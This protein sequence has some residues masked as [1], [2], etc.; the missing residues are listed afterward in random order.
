MPEKKKHFRSLS[1]VSCASMT[2]RH[3]RRWT[4]TRISSS[5]GLWCV[6]NTRLT[7]CM[8]LSYTLLRVSGQTRSSLIFGLGFDC[9]MV[10]GQ[11][12]RCIMHDAHPD[13]TMCIY[14]AWVLASGLNQY[15]S[16]VCTVHYYCCV[17]SRH[18]SLCFIDSRCSRL[19]FFRDNLPEH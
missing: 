11:R 6:L 18:L 9:D 2:G 15:T 3:C 10:S 17:S 5:E 1:P 7:C 14:D 8:V 13:Q 4:S 19:W 16:R 12:S